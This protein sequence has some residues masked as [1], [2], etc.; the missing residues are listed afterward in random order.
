MDAKVGQERSMCGRHRTREAKPCV[1]EDKKRRPSAAPGATFGPSAQRSLILKRRRRCL[2]AI[3]STRACEMVLL[4][5][6]QGMDA[7]ML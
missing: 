4:R 2:V 1:P 7:Q 3:A 5:P 6:F